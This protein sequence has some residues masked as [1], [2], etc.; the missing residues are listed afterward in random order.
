MLPCP[1]SINGSHLST[2]AL[3]CA[4]LWQPHLMTLYVANVNPISN[5]LPMSMGYT[6][7]GVLLDK[8]SSQ[9]LLEQHGQL[10]MELERPSTNAELGHRTAEQIA[11]FAPVEKC[12]IPSLIYT[13]INEYKLPTNNLWTWC[14]S[15]GMVLGYTFL[16]LTRGF[17]EDDP[18][19]R[20]GCI[21]SSTTVTE[22]FLGSSRALSFVDTRNVKD[23]TMIAP[24]LPL[25][26]Q[27]ER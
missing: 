15:C 4:C 24:S 11:Q 14:P 26:V 17:V 6:E 25:S 23:W 10:A 2:L 19:N 8:Q 18:Q 9:S 27:P 13:Q 16:E 3:L 22:P 20:D 5:T 12:C 1:K 7:R 21:R